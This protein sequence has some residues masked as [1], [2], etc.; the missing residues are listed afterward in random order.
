MCGGAPARRAGRMGKTRPHNPGAGARLA[1]YS[2]IASPA[3]GPTNR[4]AVK[5][6]LALLE[7]G[8]VQISSHT[9]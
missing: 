2:R 6:Y 8:K 5:L 1:L 4:A 3:N 7:T 9:I